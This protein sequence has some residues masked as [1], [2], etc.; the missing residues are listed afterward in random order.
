MSSN[1]LFA[2]LLISEMPNLKEEDAET[3]VVGRLCFLG[4]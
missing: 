1:P 2:V 4:F 3:E